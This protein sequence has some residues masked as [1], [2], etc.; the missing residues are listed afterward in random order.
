MDILLHKKLNILI[1]L[2]KSDG[3]FHDTERKLLH[4]LLEEHGF[5]PQ[6]LAK[7]ETETLH[8]NMGPV[9]EKAELIYWS[10][11]LMQAD[12]IIHA[13]E[14]AYCKRVVG[15]LHYKEEL[16]DRYAHTKLPTLNIF[17]KELDTF[18]LS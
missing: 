14:V 12:G 9:S 7:Y 18:K 13:D 17:E 1:H 16:V 11:K 4:D 5:S 8:E 3:K 15:Q 10:I 6:E 2:A